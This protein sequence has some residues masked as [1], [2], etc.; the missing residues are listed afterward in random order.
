MWVS[1]SMRAMW[2]QKCGHFPVPKCWLTCTALLTKGKKSGSFPTCDR[3]SRSNLATFPHSANQYL[4]S[5]KRLESPNLEN[6]ADPPQALTTPYVSL[7]VWGDLHSPTAGAWLTC[8]LTAR[9]PILQIQIQK[10]TNTPA[11]LQLDCPF[12][13]PCSLCFSCSFPALSTAQHI[14]C[15]IFKRAEFEHECNILF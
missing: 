9:L 11:T 3:Y 7:H 8:H 10:Y 2:W 12:Y 6:L 14:Y 15:T 4:A 1:K 5:T 13:P